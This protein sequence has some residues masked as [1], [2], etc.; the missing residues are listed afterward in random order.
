MAPSWDLGFLP[1]LRALH[2]KEP[3][4]PFMPC[5][6]T[7]DCSPAPAKHLFLPHII[8]LIYMFNFYQHLVC[9]LQYLQCLELFSGMGK[10]GSQIGCSV[11]SPD[12]LKIHSSQ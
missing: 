11:K 12:V 1:N 4:T 2:L 6:T 3:L 10:S 7:L 9:C 8:L 5:D